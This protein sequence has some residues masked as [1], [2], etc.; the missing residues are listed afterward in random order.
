MRKVNF[1]K[2][3]LEILNTPKA[4]KILLQAEGKLS[5][6]KVLYYM[7]YE[8]NLRALQVE[9]IKMQHWIINNNQRLCVVFEGRDAA[10][11][12]GAIRRIT[13]HLNPRFY[14]VVALPKPSVQENKQWYFQRYIAQFPNAGEIVFFDRSW[15]NRAMI[16]P[17]NGFCTQEEYEQFMADVNHFEKMVTHNMVMI[18]FYCSI[19][20]EEQ[21][22]RFAKLRAN[23]LK[24]WKLNPMDKKAQE[25]WDTYSAYKK[26]MFSETNTEKNPWVVIKANKKTQARIQIINYILN[27]IPYKQ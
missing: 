26:R 25:L 16:E 1:D 12:G 3:E 22:S 20:K 27:H 4:L 13:H 2:N 14:K 7:N 5:P 21:A 17:V 8:K 10:G 24:R 19:T 11:K 15:Y 18:K 23:P 9:L 6:E